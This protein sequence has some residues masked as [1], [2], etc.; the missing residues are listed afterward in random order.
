MSMSLKNIPPFT[1]APA[2]EMEIA[3]PMNEDWQR[4]GESMTSLDKANHISV[5]ANITAGPTTQK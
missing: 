1:T 4:D 2:N 5:R 3:V